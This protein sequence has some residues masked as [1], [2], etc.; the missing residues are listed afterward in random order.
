VLS[1]TISEQA[2]IMRA[3]YL[4]SL[5]MIAPMSALN[6][7]M[8]PVTSG[9]SVLVVGNGPVQLLA[10]RLCAIRG[11]DTSLA[12]VPQFIEAAKTC[13]YDDTYPEGSIPLTI[14]P[15]AGDEA[16]AA[17]IDKC[18][19]QAEGLIIAFDSA[20]TTIPDSAINV[21]LPKAGGTNIKHVSLM[22]R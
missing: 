6:V 12:I 2:I 11:F 17:D 8:G 3:R 19:A 5:F 9:G 7:Q 1:S 4:A 16:V 14:L 20:E 15:I 10:A 22:S 18:V 13:C 21:F